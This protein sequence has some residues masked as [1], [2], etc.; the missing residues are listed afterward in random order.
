MTR[1]VLELRCRGSLNSVET[2]VPLGH[3]SQPRGEAGIPG[4]SAQEAAEIRMAEAQKACS[5]LKA[6]TVFAGQIDGSTE[7]NPARYDRFREPLGGGTACHRLYSLA[8]R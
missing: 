8:G 4:K 5:I 1:D 6:R 3:C 7:L 2:G